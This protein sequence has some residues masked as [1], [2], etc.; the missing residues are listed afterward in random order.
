M[1]MCVRLTLALVISQAF[2]TAVLA[3]PI[4][5]DAQIYKP[6]IGQKLALNSLANA[7]QNLGY[8]CDSIS[9]VTPFAFSEGLSVDCNDYRYRYEMANKGGRWDITVK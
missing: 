6:F 8:T 2:T 4:E 3:V 5:K 7:I 9:A 1:N